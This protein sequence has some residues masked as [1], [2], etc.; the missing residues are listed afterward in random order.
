MAET[1]PLSPDSLRYLL[2]DAPHPVGES[3]ALALLQINR[4]TLGRWLAGSVKVPH[5]AA[6]VLRQVAEGIP[7]GGTDHWRGFSWDGDALVTPTGERLTARQLD[8]LHWQRQYT[9]S[10]ERRVSELEAT[11]ESLR[12]VGG[13]ANDAIVSP[14]AVSAGG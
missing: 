2:H 11:I 10:L 3:R 12:R 4:T 8:G 9:R 14:P 1:R 7:P 6:L 13:S 5:S